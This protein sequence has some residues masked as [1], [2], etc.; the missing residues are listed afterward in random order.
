LVRLGETVTLPLSLATIA[1][2]GSVLRVLLKQTPRRGPSR[3]AS[4]V[5]AENPWG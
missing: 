2:I 4:T 1:V 5:D 3:S